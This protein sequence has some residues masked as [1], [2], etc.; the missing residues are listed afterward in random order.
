MDFEPL[1][2][3]QLLSDIVQRAD[4]VLVE[5]TRERRDGVNLVGNPVAVIKDKV[6]MKVGFE[7]M[8]D[9]PERE[10]RHGYRKFQDLE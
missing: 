6:D 10:Q 5:A 9:P 8:P 3:I 7:Y 4:P 2:T 1:L